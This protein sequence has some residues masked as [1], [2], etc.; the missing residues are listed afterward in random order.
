MTTEPYQGLEVV[1]EII[2]Q[3]VG[4][5]V[6]S[7]KTAAVSLKIPKVPRVVGV[8]GRVLRVADTALTPPYDDSKTASLE[9]DRVLID[10]DDLQTVQGL[11]LYIDG[12]YCWIAEC[13]EVNEPCGRDSQR[14]RCLHQ[15]LMRDCRPEGDLAVIVDHINGD[16]LD[17]RRSNLRWASHKL[18]SNNKVVSRDFL[19]ESVDRAS[20]ILEKEGAQLAWDPCGRSHPYLGYCH[21]RK[22][23]LAKP[24]I[25]YDLGAHTEL[26]HAVKVVHEWISGH[27][28]EDLSGMTAFYPVT[29]ATGSKRP[30]LR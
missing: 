12:G 6:E 9:F 22:K 27:A 1:R 21:K 24:F 26:L 17:C 16:T 20:E 23:W 15:Y 3:I 11:R 25:Q 19:R 5:A 28:P 14:S 18:N 2:N 8:E 4:S 7:T 13:G 30:R 29:Q 10:Q